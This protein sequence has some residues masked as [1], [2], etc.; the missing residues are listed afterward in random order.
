MLDGQEIA[1]QIRKN[2]EVIKV[3][4]SNLRDK[5]YIPSTLSEATPSSAETTPAAPPAAPA[6]AASPGG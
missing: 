6:P 5:E 1:D 4:V 3:T 2:D